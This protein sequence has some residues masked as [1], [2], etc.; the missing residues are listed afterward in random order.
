MMHLYLYILQIEHIYEKIE[1]PL[2]LG[3]QVKSS[4]YNFTQLITGRICHR[5]SFWLCFSPLSECSIVSSLHLHT[6]MPDESQSRHLNYSWK[7]SYAGRLAV[8]NYT[9][10][11]LLTASVHT[12]KSKLTV[13]PIQ[14]PLRWIFRIPLVTPVWLNMVKNI[15][16]TKRKLP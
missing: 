15:R 11:W 16:G 9:E 6:M 12:S 10:E 4:T 8:P 5:T 3:D 2:R 7:K 1:I 13:S 14:L